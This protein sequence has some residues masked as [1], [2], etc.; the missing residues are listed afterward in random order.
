MPADTVRFSALNDTARIVGTAVDS[1]GYVVAGSPTNLSVT[2]TTTVAIRDSV[3][4]VSRNNGVTSVA[5]SIDSVSIVLPAIVRQ[6]TDTGT[7]KPCAQQGWG[8]S[9]LTETHRGQVV[10]VGEE[11]RSLD[12]GHASSLAF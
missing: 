7:H 9:D 1:L 2:D 10:A 5:F 3:S 4:L 6:E 11:R 8:R 12:R